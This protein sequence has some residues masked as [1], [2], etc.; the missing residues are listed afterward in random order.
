VGG[1]TI[2]DAKGRGK[3]EKPMMEAQKGTARYAAEFSVRANVITVVEDSQAEKVIKTILETV[4]TGSAGDGKI[5]VSTVIDA[6]D[7]GTKSRGE[8]A[9]G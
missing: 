1:C 8:E 4:S 6:I 9:V 2:L 7:I 5:F 3:G